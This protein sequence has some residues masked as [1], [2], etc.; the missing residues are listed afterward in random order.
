MDVSRVDPETAL[1]DCENL[2]GEEDLSADLSGL[3]DVGALGVGL[4]S[5]K[6]DK[7]LVSVRCVFSSF[8]NINDVRLPLQS[9]PV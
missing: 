5:G 7:V 1:I 8:N 3:L 9:S 6:E 4:E 2:G